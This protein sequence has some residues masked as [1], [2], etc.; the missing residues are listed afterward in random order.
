MKRSFMVA[1]MA[2]EL[3]W[4]GLNTSGVPVVEIANDLLKVCER[5]GMSV[6]GG[7][8][9]ETPDFKKDLERGHKGE[10]ELLRLYPDLVRLDGFNADF[11]DQEGR[12]Y[13]LKTD[14]YTSG[15]FFMERWSD[16][17]KQK[18]G[19]PWQSKQKN[20]DFYVY[21]FPNLKKLFTFTVGDLVNQLE[22]LKEKNVRSVQNKSWTTEGWIVKIGELKPTKEVAL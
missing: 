17:D 18:P 9:H 8:S 22:N 2:E 13:E 12:T 5:N 16:V 20:I 1:A 10:L 15:N 19:G 11:V 14:F 3:Q 6:P 4:D 21:M 7:W